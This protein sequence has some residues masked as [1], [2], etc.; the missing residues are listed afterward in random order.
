MVNMGTIIGASN[1]PRPVPPL[2]PKNSWTLWVMANPFIQTLGHFVVALIIA[3]VE[4][5]LCYYVIEPNVAGFFPVSGLVT[6]TIFLIILVLGARIVIDR[7]AVKHNAI[8]TFSTFIADLQTQILVSKQKL[9]AEDFVILASIPVQYL[10]CL[11]AKS[12]GN[13]N[14]NDVGSDY[15]PREFVNTNVDV[16]MLKIAVWCRDKGLDFSRCLQHYENAAAGE[17]FNIT[18]DIN[19]FTWVCAWIYC[20][21]VPF[22]LWGEYDNWLA[23]IGMPTIWAVLAL[24][25]GFNRNMHLY[26]VYRKHDATPVDLM[27]YAQDQGKIISSLQY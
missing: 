4:F 3:T 27:S 17:R 7:I 26:D 2:P 1:S 14:A 21:L 13:L 24:A 12:K 8:R 16:R 5:I 10:L 22:V 9:S 15:M 23:Y 18:R 19:G 20:L 6:T 25:H 11:R